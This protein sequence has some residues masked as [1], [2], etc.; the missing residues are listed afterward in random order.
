MKKEKKLARRSTSAGGKILSKITPLGDRVLVLPLEL[1]GGEHKKT[2]SGIYVP[3]SEA[4]EKPERGTVIAVG[5][6]HYDDGKLVPMSVKV[7]DKVMFSKYGY[8]EVKEGEKKFFIIK[9]ENILAV[10][11]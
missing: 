3:D 8:D 4:K 5:K 11:K 6:G 9:E 1:S 7:G 10:I 2:E